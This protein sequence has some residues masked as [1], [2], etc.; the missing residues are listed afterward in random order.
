MPGKTK[1]CTPKKLRKYSMWLRGKQAKSRKQLNSD[2]TKKCDKTTQ[3]DE[4]GHG[5]E[6]KRANS[7]LSK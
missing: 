6:C 4:H 3:E 2:L 7:H 1:S 5:Q